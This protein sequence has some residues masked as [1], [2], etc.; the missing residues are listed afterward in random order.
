MSVLVKLAS[1][2][3]RLDRAFELCHEISEK[4]KFQLN[5]HVYSNLVQACTTNNA[6]PRAFDVLGQMVRNRV[7][8]DVRVYTLLI[9]ACIASREGND[10]AG[11]VRAALGLQDAHPVFAK[12]TNLARLQKGLSSDLLV[13]VLEGISGQCNDNNLAITLWQEIKHLPNLKLPARLQ[14]RLASEACRK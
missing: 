2:A 12:A 13:E 4:Y 5:V 1:R 7:R 14:L 6:L 8:P 11:L 10:G 9:R 3:K